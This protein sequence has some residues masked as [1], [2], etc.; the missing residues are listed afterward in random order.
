MR[1]LGY[2]RVS[3]HEQGES[4]AGLGAQRSAILAEAARRDWEMVD[5][6]EDSGYSGRDFKRPAVM[7]A[8]SMLERGEVDALVVAKLDRLSRSMLDFA[9]VMA[10]ARKEGWGLISLD[11]GVDTMSPA[12]EAMMSV[13]VTFAQFERR[14]IGQRT[15][16]AL[17]ELRS[18]GKAYGSVPFGFR[19]DGDC[20][21]PDDTEQSVLVRIKRLRG[22]GMS[23]DRIAQSLN[24]SGVPAKRGGSWHAMSVRSVVL[25]AP[26]VGRINAEVAA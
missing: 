23:Y 19:R 26:R 21:I 8:M 5:L 9:G 18:Q 4:G 10:K 7:A 22:R 15:S 20:L 13:L 24:G 3:T 14:L 25:T 17:Q 11:C 1:V 6:L 16:E 2:V 12:G